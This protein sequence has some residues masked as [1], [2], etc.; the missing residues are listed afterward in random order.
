[1]V[2]TKGAVAWQQLPLLLYTL[3]EALFVQF[4]LLAQ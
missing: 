3:V 4:R 2:I 1:M